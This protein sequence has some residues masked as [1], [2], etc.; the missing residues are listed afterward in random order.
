[1]DPSLYP[2]MAEVED[3]HWW[4][5]GRR[6]IVRKLLTTLGL[7]A[8][9]KILEAGC[10]TGGNLP[11]LAHFGAVSG[12]ESD[13][14]ALE[15]ARRRGCAELRSG[16]LPEAV[17]FGAGEFDLAVMT[18]VLEHLERE[19]ES[20]MAIRSCLKPG[21]W[22]LITVPALPSLW[23]VHDETHHHLRRYLLGTLRD[24][25]EQAGYEVNYISYFNTVLL[26]MV[27]GV[28]AARRLAGKSNTDGHDLSMP[29]EAINKIL[30]TIFSAERYIVGRVSLPIGVSLIVL[31]R[32]GGMLDGMRGGVRFVP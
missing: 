12:F 32:K 1:M 15:F 24:L 7:P 3:E 27:A 14:K 18:D 31:A 23:S 28:R 19:R 9:A 29:S 21:G 4:F 20:L 30:R 10:G 17:P 11:M 26:P 13:A 6:A 25:V 22:L 16:R 2:R 5:A 8:E